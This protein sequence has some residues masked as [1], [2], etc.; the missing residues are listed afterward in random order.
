L[1]TEIAVLLC[2]KLLAL[3]GLYFAFFSHAHRMPADAHAVS[4]RVLN[5]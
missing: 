5:P 3:C 1:R 4:A 2:V